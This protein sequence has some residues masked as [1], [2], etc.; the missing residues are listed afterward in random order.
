[1][2]KNFLDLKKFAKSDLSDL[3]DNNTLII[4][5]GKFKAVNNITKKNGIDNTP[6][7]E[8]LACEKIYNLSIVL[9]Y[10]Q[11]N[12]KPRIDRIIARLDKFPKISF[13][14]SSFL[15]LDLQLLDMILIY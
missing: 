12:I 3:S 4:K 7:E 14:T 2:Y 5:D 15:V 10:I 6:W 8:K 13:N 9:K 11:I 1:M